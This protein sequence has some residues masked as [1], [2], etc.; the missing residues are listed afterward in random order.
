MTSKTPPQAPRHPADL[1]LSL[2]LRWSLFVHAAL[3]AGVLLKSLVFPGKPILYQPTLRVDLVGL[4]DILKKD[5]SKLP[6][7]PPMQE[8][9]SQEKAPEAKAPPKAPAK[10]SERASPDE[11]VLKPKHSSES[12][13]KAR[14]KKLKNALARIKALEKIKESVEDRKTPGALA[15]KGNAISRG[16]SFEGKEGQSL[17]AIYFDALRAQLQENWTLPVWLARQKF[18]AQVQLMIDSRGQMR[19]FKFIKPSGNAQ[20]DEAVKKALQESQP[21]PKPPESLASSL[22]TD[23]IL[24][25]FPL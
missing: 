23:G 15:I 24:I 2:G 22:G 14:R 16:S 1:Q 5:L 25:G 19:G 8:T 21:Y 6:K 10:T 17:E 18:A 9:A 4:P 20:F 11:M 3:I 12:D 13:P 7:L